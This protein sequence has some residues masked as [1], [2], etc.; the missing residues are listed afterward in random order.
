MGV[1]L[2]AIESDRFNRFGGYE[3]PE[4]FDRHVGLQS[5][6]SEAVHPLLSAQLQAQS[7]QRGSQCQRSGVA[8]TPRTDRV[9]L[10]SE[11]YETGPLSS[12]NSMVPALVMAL[13]DTFGARV[14]RDSFTRESHLS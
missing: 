9:E 11:A 3:Q 10:S 8:R 4:R 6:V 12:S 2:G 7:S 13:Q 5:R 14:D 1:M